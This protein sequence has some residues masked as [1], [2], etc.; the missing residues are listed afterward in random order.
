MSTYCPSPQGFDL[1]V[2]STNTHILI[3]F[4]KSIH[5]HSNRVSTN[6]GPHNKVNV[7]EL[8]ARGRLGR[9]CKICRRKHGYSEWSRAHSNASRE[10][11]SPQCQM[12]QPSRWLWLHHAEGGKTDH[13]KPEPWIVHRHLP[14]KR[15]PI[16]DHDG[17]VEKKEHL[18]LRGWFTQKS[19][20]FEG[21]AGILVTS[22]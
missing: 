6:P 17:H 4:L 20:T 22:T 5:S 12:Q 8:R 15:R 10:H 7:D 1:I 2:E 13:F 19:D 16:R 18:Q 3:V 11:A 21:S 14:Q 9:G